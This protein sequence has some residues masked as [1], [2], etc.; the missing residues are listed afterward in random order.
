MS[1]HVHLESNLHLFNM[2]SQLYGPVQER[3]GRIYVVREGK[4]EDL[5]QVTAHFLEAANNIFKV[6]RAIFDKNLAVMATNKLYYVNQLMDCKEFLNPLEEIKKKFQ[7]PDLKDYPTISRADEFFI[8]TPFLIILQTHSLS[9]GSWGRPLIRLSSGFLDLNEVAE[10]FLQCCRSMLVDVMENDKPKVCF[11]VI[12]P[13]E[14]VQFSQ[15]LSKLKK[16]YIEID[17]NKRNVSILVSLYSSI[18]SNYKEILIEIKRIEQILLAG[19]EQK[20]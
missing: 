12:N 11:E 5:R 13:L 10:D 3:S 7:S 15:I 9:F 8:V 1:L 16:Y 18:F 20:S 19:F 17:M 4:R 14:K 2:I 6:E